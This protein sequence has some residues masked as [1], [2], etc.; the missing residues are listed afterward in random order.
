VILDRVTTLHTIK[1]ARVQSRIRCD[2]CERE[3]PSETVKVVS[4]MSDL[5]GVEAVS[6]AAPFRNGVIGMCDRCEGHFCYRT[7]LV[8]KWTGP[9]DS[10]DRIWVRCH[11]C[12]GRQHPPL[13]YNPRK[14]IC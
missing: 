11:A 3:V 13:V 7:C 6:L 2:H 9:S 10:D 12:A 4:E 14:A 8:E 1:Y 5:E